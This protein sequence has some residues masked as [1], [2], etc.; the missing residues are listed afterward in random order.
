[1]GKISVNSRGCF[2]GSIRILAD[3]SG[4]FEFVEHLETSTKALV[5]NKFLRCSIV[6]APIF[7]YNYENNFDIIII[8]RKCTHPLMYPFNAFDFLTDPI[9]FKFIRAGMVATF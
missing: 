2:N 7:L 3:P 9:G 1:V 4:F 5:Y 6:N 8:I